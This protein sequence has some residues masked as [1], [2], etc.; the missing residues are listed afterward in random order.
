MLQQLLQYD[1]MRHPGIHRMLFP[2]AAEFKRTDIKGFGKTVHLAHGGEPAAAYP[3]GYVLGR[4]ADL[5]GQTASASFPRKTESL[6]TV[7]F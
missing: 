5:F 7:A 4:G 3:V 6:V 1:N 2:D